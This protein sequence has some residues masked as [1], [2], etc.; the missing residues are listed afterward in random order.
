MFKI[1]SKRV[2]ILL[3]VVL[4]SLITIS[5]L[6]LSNLFKPVEVAVL[7]KDGDSLKITRIETDNV[8]EANLLITKLLKDPNVVAASIPGKVNSMDADPKRAEQWALNDLEA[9]TV[10]PLGDGSGV[11]VAVIDTGVDGNHPDLAGVVLPGFDVIGD[12]DGRFDPNGHGT[13]IAGIIGAIRNNGIG[14]AGLAPGVKILPVR[15]LDETG[16]GDDAGIAEG[17]LWAADNG[18]TI[19]NL[20]LGS[21]DKDP[22]LA[23]SIENVTNRGVTVIAASGNDGTKGNPTSYPGALNNV[24]AV[25]AT[26]YNYQKALFSTSGSYVDISAP[27]VSIM[28]T[29]PNNGYAY[30]SGTSMA[31]PYV[32]ASAALVQAKFGLKGTAVTDRLT[33]SATDIGE[34]GRD[35]VFGH[36]A[37]DVVAAMTDGQPRPPRETTMPTFP[38]MPSLPNVELPGLPELVKP[39]LTKPELPA[40]PPLPTFDP[41]ELPNHPEL[42]FDKD[43]RIESK[44]T[45]NQEERNRNQI[46]MEVKLTVNTISLGKR[47]LV[48]EMFK[49]NAWV[50]VTDTETDM[51]GILKYKTSEVKDTKLKISFPGDRVGK[52]TSTEIT[53][54]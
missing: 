53:L 31:T 26:S 10:A 24:T 13:H 32:T 17:V 54:K 35:D 50:K 18:A 36:G 43:L 44:I 2:L 42:N 11:T 51:R 14:I 34:P 21:P 23:A 49:D 25:A 7:K 15:A 37:L 22:V 5:S 30:S 38:N 3:C 33:S 47:P 8:K 46:V 20:S 1:K 52:A 29:W 41:Q 16:Y 27:G 40:L 39:D 4:L 9:E 19:I 6:A 28:S 48:V 45:V 12:T